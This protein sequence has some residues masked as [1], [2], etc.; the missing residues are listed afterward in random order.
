MNLRLLHSFS[1]SSSREAR[2]S[3]YMGS[4]PEEIDKK[5][6]RSHAPTV[7]FANSVEN[8]AQNMNNFAGI[9]IQ[10]GSSSST[11]L[12]NFVFYNDCADP[13]V[14]NKWMDL[15]QAQKET[16]E[17]SS[18]SASP[19]PQIQKQINKNYSDS[20]DNLLRKDSQC[21]SS[22]TYNSNFILNSSQNLS[23]KDYPTAYDEKEVGLVKQS[24]NR[25]MD[26]VNKLPVIKD[27]NFRLLEKCRS[28]D[29]PSM[30]HM[31]PP[32]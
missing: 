4:V 15:Y 17:N 22:S 32:N 13:V 21:S 2:S 12:S 18:H 8:F 25:S 30:K 11:D 1:I 27:Y 16:N 24:I 10:L 6:E 31:H 20:A 19:L 26:A 9:G 5:D 14:I 3:P 28:I 23:S 7:N 29:L